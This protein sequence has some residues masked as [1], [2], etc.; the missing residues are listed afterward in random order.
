MGDGEKRPQAC[1][2]D[3]Q[4]VARRSLYAA[5][6]LERGHALAAEDVACRRPARGLSPALL[7]SLLGRHLRRAVAPEQL[8]VE[9]DFE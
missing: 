1:E 2:R 4:A 3:V 8:L 7:R 5:R 6:A 9:E